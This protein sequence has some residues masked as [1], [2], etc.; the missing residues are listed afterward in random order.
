MTKKL[1]VL[2]RPQLLVQFT[3][4]IAIMIGVSACS[5][6]Q[7]KQTNDKATPTPSEINDFPKR[8]GLLND[9]ADVLDKAPK[10]RITKLLAELNQSKGSSKS[11][12]TQRELNRL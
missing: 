8:Q 4:L 12:S 1:S 10:D 3:L 7:V 9:Y 6:F 11:R 2:S 5:R